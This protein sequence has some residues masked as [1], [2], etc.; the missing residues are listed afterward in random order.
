MG[1]L[2]DRGGAQEDGSLPEDERRLTAILV[3]Q[4]R[5]FGFWETEDLCDCRNNLFMFMERKLGESMEFV[6]DKVLCAPEERLG[7]QAIE[8][9][10]LHL[11]RRE[12]FAIV[13]RHRDLRSVPRYRGRLRDME[14]GSEV[15]TVTELACVEDKGVPIPLPYETLRHEQNALVILATDDD[16]GLAYYS[17]VRAVRHESF[18]IRMGFLVATARTMAR[19]HARAGRKWRD[20]SYL[21]DLARQF[22]RTRR[23]WPGHGASCGDRGGEKA[24]EATAGAARRALRERSIVVGNRKAAERDRG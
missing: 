3:R 4:L 12:P 14:D 22:S 13:V 23:R 24:A 8:L 16:G 5:Q 1:E 17:G 11:L 21:E 2:Q 7:M 20:L 18:A 15:A 9:T 6:V 19:E 10:A